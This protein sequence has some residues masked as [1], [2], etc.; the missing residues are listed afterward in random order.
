EDVQSKMFELDFPS[1][2]SGEIL[3]AT[4]E[5]ALE[6]PGFDPARQRKKIRVPPKDDSDVS[7]FMI[8]PKHTSSLRLNLQVLSANVEIGSRML[9]TTS[10]SATHAPPSLSYE[11]TSLPIKPPPPGH[12]DHRKAEEKN[13]RRIE[14]ERIR[15]QQ[16]TERHHLEA[17][18]QAEQ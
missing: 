4:L 5:L 7:M 15:A 18:R 9:V 2:S 10:V 6:S 3:P 16:A 12:V 17:E 8:T 1:D 13:R 14:E 11:V